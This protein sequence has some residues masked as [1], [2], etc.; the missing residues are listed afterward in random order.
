MFVCTDVLTN[1]KMLAM[2]LSRKGLSCD[3]AVDGA[4]AVT[5]VQEK[6]LDYYDIIFMDSIMPVLSGPLAAKQLRALGYWK[7][8]IGVTGNAMDVDI[9]EYEEAGADMILTKPV[10]VH[11]LSKVLEFCRVHGC[12]S[13]FNYKPNR[14]SSGSDGSQVLKKH[15]DSLPEVSIL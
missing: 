8:L 1:R 4:E 12:I 10:Q 7:L 5:M 11:I 15:S 6:G 13:H 9:R 2:I 14:M 3:L